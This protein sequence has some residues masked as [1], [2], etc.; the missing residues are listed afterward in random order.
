SSDCSQ[1]LSDGKWRS[2]LR[3]SRSSR[4]PV[5][6]SSS[7]EAERSPAWMRRTQSRSRVLSRKDSDIARAPLSFE[8]RNNGVPGRLGGRRRWTALSLASRRD[9]SETTLRE[10]VGRGLFSS[11][12]H[13]TLRG[14]LGCGYTASRKTAIWRRLLVATGDARAP[15]DVENP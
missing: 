8:R 5:A 14:Y 4:S 12:S 13:Q 2:I 15:A 3:V 9:P 6:R 7:S 1:R 11:N 10:V